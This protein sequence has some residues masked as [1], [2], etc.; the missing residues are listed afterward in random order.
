MREGGQFVDSLEARAAFESLR[1]ALLAA[2]WRRLPKAGLSFI[3]ETDANYLALRAVLKQAEGEIE[4][5]VGF[6][7]HAL[8]PV[9]RRYSTNKME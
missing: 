7:S 9:E 4:F 8:S 6:Y 3:L 2:P 1:A 5:P